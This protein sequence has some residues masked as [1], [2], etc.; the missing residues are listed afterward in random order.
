MANTASW[1]I[2][3]LDVQSL[4]LD[5]ENIR[6]RSVKPYESDILA[7]LYEYEEVFALATEI[8]RDGFFD[9][10]LPIVVRDGK[11]VI[12]LEGNRR[13]S[14]LKGLANPTAVPSYKK[15]LTELRK[16]VSRDTLIGLQKVRVIEAPDRASAQPILASLHTRNPKRSWPLDQQAMFYHAQLGPDV[17]VKDL[18]ARY[19]AVAEKIPRFIRMAEMY[20]LVLRSNLGEV[21]LEEFSKS[22]QFKMSIFERLYSSK[23][24]RSKIG[25]DFKDDGQVKITGNKADVNRILSKVV[26]DMK[27]G[28]LNTRRLGQQGSKE[29]TGYVDS[30]GL[31]SASP[32][33]AKGIH[34]STVP[35]GAAPVGTK[36]SKRTTTLDTAGINFGL[37]S[38]GLERRY[39]EL[40]GI[41]CVIYP[42]ATLDLLRTVLECALKQYLSEANDPILPSKPG[43]FVMLG[44]ALYHALKHFN[45][46]ATGNKG[47]VQIITKLKVNPQ[48][49][50]QFTK[51][52]TALNAVNHNP[53]VFFGPNE[54]REIWENAQPLIKVLLAGTPS[55]GSTIS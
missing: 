1:P 16:S 15:Q 34:G 31:S 50:G 33:V 42:N 5:T 2:N 29:F 8:A 53:G 3:T 41:N 12:V 48:N 35:A 21:T 36:A 54:V 46:Q 13:I 26:L 20:N 11:N 7:Y 38:P 17:T 32:R 43:N 10:D 47:I 27:T 6:L 49:E 14:A 25:A 55:S 18:Q 51:S 40:K 45:G 22:K 52:A 9:H 23:E 37:N 24:F 4:A 44:D 30:L 19:P 28:F 39:L